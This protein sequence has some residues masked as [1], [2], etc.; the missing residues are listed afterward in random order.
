MRRHVAQHDADPAAAEPGEG[1]EV[2][3]HRVGREAARRHLGV[4][5][6]HA[7][8][9]EQL[10]LEVVRQLELVAEP[11]LAA[12]ALHQPGV[13]HRRADLVGDRGHQLPVAQA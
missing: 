12:V 1:V 8:R 2:A 11:L 6:Q 7:G 9:R 3:A 4:A 13:L 10:E 5:L